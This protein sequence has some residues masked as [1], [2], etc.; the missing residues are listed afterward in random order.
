MRYSSFRRDILS[1]TGNML[2]IVSS[3]WTRCSIKKN[4]MQTFALMWHPPPP[5]FIC[6]HFDGTP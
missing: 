1:K 2:T 6:L 5:V 4:Y 3:L